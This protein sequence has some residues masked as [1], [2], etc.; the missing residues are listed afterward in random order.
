MNYEIYKNG[1]WYVV[2]DEHG[3]TV[4]VEKTLESCQEAIESGII[5]RALNQCK[6][7]C[8]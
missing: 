3:R 4:W 8:R 2:T 7:M 1:D 5:D 6:E